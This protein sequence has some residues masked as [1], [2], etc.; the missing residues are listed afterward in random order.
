MLVAMQW[1]N[2]R[3]T[4]HGVLLCL[5]GIAGLGL[6]GCSSPGA[7][8][9]N[10]D[11]ALRPGGGFAYTSRRVGALEYNLQGLIGESWLRV[12]AEDGEEGPDPIE[13]P[14]TDTLGFL[15]E[16]ADAESDDPLLLATQVRQFARYA[17]ACPSALA[18]ERALLE[19]GSHA[20]RLGVESPATLVDHPASAEEVGDQLARV[21]AAWRGILDQ[22]PRSESEGD[23]TA[24]ALEQALADA[25]AQCAVLDFDVSG[26][27]RLVQG[28]SAMAAQSSRTGRAHEPVRSLELQLQRRLVSLAL[29]H[30]VRDRSPIARAAAFR[31]AHAAYGASFLGEALVSLVMPD[32]DERGS[33]NL[34]RAFGL[35]A[36]SGVVDEQV[37]LTVFDLVRRHGLPAAESTEDEQRL[38]ASQLFVLVQV[39]HDFSAY[40]ERARISAMQTLGVVSGADVCALRK[41]EWESWWSAWVA[42]ASGSTRTDPAAGSDT[43]P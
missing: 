15:V 29:A 14:T 7:A 2:I 26:G 37:F 39:A 36:Q 38:K 16:L 22:P 5:G 8:S 9:Q 10:L 41:E 17:V 20:K 30:G 27:W 31:S 18:R 34:T 11:G 43:S 28:V 32:R 24:V 12:G 1:W 6:V 23:S 35:G 3:G 19:L 4:V 25:C 42:E 21:I 40:G 13:N 33:R